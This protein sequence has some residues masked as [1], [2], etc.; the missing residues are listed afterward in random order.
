MF[1]LM[2]LMG[3]IGLLIALFETYRQPFRKN[4]YAPALTVGMFG[5]FAAI[6]LAFV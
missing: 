6:M 1:Y 5:S 4:V 2:L 3:L